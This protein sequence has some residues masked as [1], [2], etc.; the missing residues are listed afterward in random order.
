MN[1]IKELRQAND[2]RQEDLAHKLNIS[3]RTVGHYETGRR[4]PDIETI[5]K[6]CD[7]FGCTA[8]YLLGRSEIRSFELSA[9]EA[10]LLTGYRALSEPG[11][12]Y[13]RHS[14]ALAALAHA[15]KNGA[16]SDL[17]TAEN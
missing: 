9:D 14:L 4:A 17:E 10:A 13:V 12:E 7:I 2:W 8:D 16:V 3:D 1:R 5:H 6:L 11:R 15:G